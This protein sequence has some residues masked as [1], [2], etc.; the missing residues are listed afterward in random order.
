MQ[1]QRWQAPRSEDDVAA[2]RPWNNHQLLQ[3]RTHHSPACNST[4]RQGQPVRTSRLHRAGHDGKTD[5]QTC[6]VCVWQKNLSPKI[7]AVFSTATENF[8]TRLCSSICHSQL[9]NSVRRGFW[10][11]PILLIRFYPRLGVHHT[12]GLRVHRGLGPWP[13]RGSVDTCL[14][15]TTT[16][17][18]MS[19]VACV[20][21]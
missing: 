9:H 21:L 14:V 17:H 12:S 13:Y 5:Q 1:W 6:T 18:G 11:P 10:V 8:Y 4:R 15:P 16:E 7:S 19:L 3:S 2:G 20:R